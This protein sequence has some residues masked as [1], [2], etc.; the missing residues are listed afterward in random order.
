MIMGRPKTMDRPFRL[1]MTLSHEERDLVF[2]LAAR[3]RVDVST[4]VRR[5]VFREAAKHLGWTADTGTRRAK[6]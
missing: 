1:N 4:Y 5:L 6:K 2:K 3:E